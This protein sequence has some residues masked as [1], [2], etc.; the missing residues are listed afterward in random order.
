MS[1]N[2]HASQVGY[3]NAGPSAFLTLVSDEDVVILDVRTPAEFDGGHLQGALNIDVQ[4]PAF[5]SRISRL[6]TDDSFAL[7]CRAG[8]R[9]EVAAAFMVSQGFNAVTNS[10]SGIAEL[11]SAGAVIVTS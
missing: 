11:G 7:Y 8:R 2:V 9:S 4:D 3:S 1:N 6:N 5:A 10:T